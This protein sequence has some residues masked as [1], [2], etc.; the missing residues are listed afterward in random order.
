MW[1]GQGHPAV[2][3]PTYVPLPGTQPLSTG[4][5]AIAGATEGAQPSAGS[6]DGNGVVAGTT[7]APAL[8]VIHRS[9]GAKT[10]VNLL[11][12][13]ERWALPDNQKVTQASLTI[14]GISIKDLREL[15]MKLPPKVH[16]ELQITLPPEGGQLS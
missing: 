8:P 1:G 13:L 9:L 6:A 4:L 16:A 5:A 14:N 3:T 12:D 10:G 7:V 2:D 11:G 15:C